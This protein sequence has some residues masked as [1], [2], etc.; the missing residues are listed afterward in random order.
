VPRAAAGVT[1]LLG[2]QFVGHA[3]AADDPA[4]TPPGTAPQPPAPQAAVPQVPRRVLGKTGEKVPILLMGGMIKFDP[5]F[6]PR[7]AECLRAGVNYVDVADCYMDG[8]SERHLG[9]LLARRAQRPDV[10]ITT[11]SCKHQPEA[12]A[13]CFRRASRA[14]TTDR[15]RTLLPATTSRT[16]HCSTTR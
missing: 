9:T 11:K 2:P 1:A 3:G 15:V 4:G 14:C 7:L 13:A 12:A 16:P 10:W 8:A 5:A 6:D